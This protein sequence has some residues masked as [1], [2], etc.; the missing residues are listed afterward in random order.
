[1][2]HNLRVAHDGWESAAR[3]SV[4]ATL[5]VAMLA[6]WA[7]PAGAAR[8]VSTPDQFQAAASAYR[9]TGGTIVMLPGTY[10]RPLVVGPRSARHLT[11][12]GRPGTRI[13]LLLL[14]HTQ[15]VT[16]R[17]LT[18]RPV[19]SDGGVL[20]LRSRRI[21]LADLRFT[22]ARTP[23]RVSLDLDHSVGVTVQ[24]SDFS[25]CGDRWR[26]VAACLYTRGASHVTIRG[27]RF[28]DCRGCDS[29]HGR[30]GRHLVIEAN[31][32]ERALAC[33]SSRKKC[34][35]QDPI[36]FFGANGVVIRRNVFGETGHGRGQIFLSQATDHVLI[37]S[38]VFLASKRHVPGVTPMRGIVVGSHISRDLPQ[39]VRIVNNT[40]LSGD[41]SGA[42][43]GSVV[44]SPFYASIAAHLRP[45]LANNVI[46]RLPQWR[47]C[48]RIRLSVQ[49]VVAHGSGCS[50]G[51]RVGDS[52]LT[53]EG[54][55]TAGSALLIDRAE[56][57][58]APARDILDHVRIGPPDIGAYEHVP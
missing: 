43:L 7:E 55:P 6:V 1:M 14:E 49:N 39:D 11:V 34:F 52:F 37:V 28:H 18:V 16:L 33:R 47:V 13:H 40:I 30:A 29:I 4:L 35:H 24:N 19:G 25:H 22:A 3:R 50:A 58:L 2:L 36:E 17:G 48:G 23:Y 9:H 31:R 53:A 8:Y 5:A 44:L 46:A 12:E 45:L 26:S 42:G 51:D 10:A 57:A 32:F 56:P 54:R 15:A 41:R 20:A 27:N 38:N 21:A